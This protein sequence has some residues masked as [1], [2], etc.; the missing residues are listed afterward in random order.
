MP[1]RSEAGGAAPTLTIVN[2]E[3]RWTRFPIQWVP[4]RFKA[5]KPHQRT[6]QNKVLQLKPGANTVDLADWK[7]IRGERAGDDDRESVD[8][9]AGL[10]EDGT[11]QELEKPIHTM[12]VAEAVKV[13][14]L[15]IDLAILLGVKGKD[16]RQRVQSAVVKQL[17]AIKDDAHTAQQLAATAS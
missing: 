1:K 15:T 14:K 5:L 8:L 6:V 16:K 9:A 10:V 12:P 7:T 17:K 4:D 13:V 3:A 11:L 2:H